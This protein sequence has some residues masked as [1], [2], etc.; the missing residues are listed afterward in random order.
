MK[1]EQPLTI[2]VLRVLAGLTGLLCCIGLF[3][4]VAANGN[5]EEGVMQQAR[6][7]NLFFSG[8]SLS[9]MLWVASVLVDVL[10]KIERNT[11]AR[12]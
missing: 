11:R 10:A 7:L 9:L 5:S 1:E 12:R 6:A 8:A 4:W 3:Q 2:L